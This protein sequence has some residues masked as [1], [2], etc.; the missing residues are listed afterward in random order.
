MS[1]RP[2]VFW[3]LYSISA[4]V[5]LCCTPGVTHLVDK[6]G[7]DELTES[8][9]LLGI[10]ITTFIVYFIYEN[11]HHRIRRSLPMAALLGFFAFLPG[12][13]IACV[14]SLVAWLQQ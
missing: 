3:L 4:A 10:F 12:I 11:K 2:F 7:P 5:G 14:F 6:H 1:N 8:L 9:Y 13:V